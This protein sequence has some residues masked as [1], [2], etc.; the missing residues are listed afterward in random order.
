MGAGRGFLEKKSELKP[1]NTGEGVNE[2]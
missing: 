2:T 1:K